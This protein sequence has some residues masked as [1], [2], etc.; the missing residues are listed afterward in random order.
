MLIKFKEMLLKIKLVRKFGD[1]IW[2][3]LDKIE[4]AKAYRRLKKISKINY[5]PNEK[6]KVVF[7][8]QCVQVWDKISSI[9]EKMREDEKFDVYILAI[10]DI[11]DKEGNETFTY[12]S[13]TYDRVINASEKEGECFDLEGLHPNYVFY[14]RP[15]DSYLPK[16]YRSDVISKYAKICYT[17]Y[18]FVNLKS[19]EKTCFPNNFFRN[20]YFYFTADKITEKS[21]VEQ[22]PKA[23][24]KGYRHSVYKGYPI[25]EK[26]N[27]INKKT[28]L[29][30]PTILWTPRWTN[31]KELGGS[32]FLN[33][34]KEIYKYAIND[35]NVKLIFRPHP[36]LFYHF[37]ETGALSEQDIESY[38]N[39]YI[40]AENC[41]LDENASYYDTFENADILIT[42]ISSMLFEWYITEKP[43]IYCDTGVN[44]DF[45]EGMKKEIKGC[46]IAYNWEDV[47]VFLKQLKNGED[48][49]KEKRMAICNNL[50]GKETLNATSNIIETI[51]NDFEN[52]RTR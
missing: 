37:K 44:N 11:T 1:F 51:R 3:I 47:K 42:D 24:K 2:H 41:T 9:Y 19:T 14:T 48:S 6:I 32:N 38:K 8:A 28:N 5:E 27:Q 23:H 18:A 21:N 10:S 22:Y 15:Y 31:N 45:S 29:H 33:Y 7:L 17:P 39:M 35:K 13:K 20:I 26:Y 49:L 4:D 40:S 50:F 36:L 34:Y 46:Y 52:R 43:I 12:Y 16:Q 25:L 30:N